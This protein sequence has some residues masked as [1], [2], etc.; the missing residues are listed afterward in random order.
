M[1]DLEIGN[2]RVRMQVSNGG[3]EAFARVTTTVNS[4]LYEKV[5]RDRYRVQV[6]DHETLGSFRAAVGQLL[7]DLGVPA[8]TR[9]KEAE[10]DSWFMLLT[11]VIWNNQGGA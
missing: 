7:V 5:E 9:T 4:D 2:R 10:A 11:Q 1:L 8:A 3:I 6:S